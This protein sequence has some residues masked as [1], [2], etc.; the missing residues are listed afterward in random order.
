MDIKRYEVWG[1][2]RKTEFGVGRWKFKVCNSNIA[3]SLLSVRA[4]VRDTEKDFF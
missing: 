4:S 2:F 3:V 1:R